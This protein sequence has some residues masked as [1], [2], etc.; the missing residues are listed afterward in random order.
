MTTRL[1]LNQIT[2][3]I[4]G[5]KMLTIDQINRIYREGFDILLKGNSHRGLKGEIDPAALEILIYL[6]NAESEYDRDITLLHELIH[7]REE[8]DPTYTPLECHRI[9]EEAIRTYEQKP[10]ILQYVKELYE[11]G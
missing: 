11:L 8:I 1:V 9:D 2:F 6:A 7:A 3:I 4:D 10:H 5:S